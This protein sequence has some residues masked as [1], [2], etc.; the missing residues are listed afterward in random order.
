[1]DYIGFH[2]QQGILVW[3]DLCIKSPS[4]KKHRL[5]LFL[6]EI[7]IFIVLVDSRQLSF[8]IKIPF[9]QLEL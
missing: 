2:P 9:V 8:Y 7:R 4:K 6:Y 3:F 5:L 1:M